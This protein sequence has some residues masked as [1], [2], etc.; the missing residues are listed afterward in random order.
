MTADADISDFGILFALLVYGAV[1]FAGA[2]GP[3]LP[4]A[5]KRTVE[6]PLLTGPDDRHSGETLTISG[7]PCTGG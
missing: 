4:T 2:N 3:N 5:A 6:V 7:V 1:A